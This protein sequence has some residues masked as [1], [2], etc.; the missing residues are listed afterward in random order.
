MDV[1]TTFLY[2]DLEEKIYMD[3]P[4]GFVASS[5]EKKVNQLHRTSRKAPKESHR[6]LEKELRKITKDEAISGQEFEKFDRN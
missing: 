5:N 2:G 3:Q 6:E 1:K 4:E